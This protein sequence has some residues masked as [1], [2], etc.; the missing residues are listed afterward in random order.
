MEKDGRG[1]LKDFGELSPAELALVTACRSG[2][3]ASFG[4]QRPGVEKPDNRVR[5]ELVRFFALGGDKDNPVREA[6]VQL[7]GAWMVD[8]L[9][10]D[11]TVVSRP[12]SLINCVIEQ[13][14]ARRARLRTLNLHG[15]QLTKGLNGDAL[16]CEGPMFLRNGFTAQASVRLIAAEIGVGLDCS[17]AR[18]DGGGD[19]AILLDGA[20][21]AGTLH[22]DRAHI[23]GEVR[24]VGA[25]IKGGLECHGSRLNNP[26]GDALV[27]NRAKLA[28]VCLRDECH[29]IGA[30]LFKNAHVLGNVICTGGSFDAGTD[31]WG[32]PESVKETGSYIALSFAGTRIDGAL[33]LKGVTRIDGVLDLSDLHA[34]RLTDDADSW[35]ASQGELLLDGFVY[36][37]FSNAPADAGSRIAWLDGQVPGHLGEAFRSQP[38]EQLITVFRTLGHPE[39]AR[40]VAIEKQ[41]RLRRAGK[42]VQGARAL[43]W[44]YGAMAG[45]GYRPLR[46]L[47]AIACVWLACATAYGLG[48][49]YGLIQA[50][51]P[52][53]GPLDPLVYSADILLPVVDFGHA[54]EWKIAMNSVD[55]S[56]LRWAKALRLL[57]WT[58]I[59]FGWLAGVLL[60]SAAGTLIKKG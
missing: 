33:T 13:I 57:Y 2:R 4:S 6:G 56:P 21:I 60:A 36:G 43:H 1:S 41:T 5:A 8:V 29:A 20:T 35:S 59:A 16:R 52:N 38:W 23:F 25:E 12:L 55:G 17:S 27:C 32:S 49:A 28:S 7:H 3:D 19:T 44:L 45:Y 11:D 50:V 22:L 26:Q 34:N 40:I 9:N 18:F 53:R 58:E 37:R 47:V 31:E 39:D 30:V 24:L 42:V 14:D 48:H 54:A 10:L 15:S 46:L 51:S